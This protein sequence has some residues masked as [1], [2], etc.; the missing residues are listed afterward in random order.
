MDPRRELDSCIVVGAGI[1]G[2][3]AARTLVDRGFEVLV[4]DK[5][6]GVGG[7]MATRWFEPAAGAAEVG[8]AVWD[9][10]A[11]FFTARDGAFKAWVDEWLEAGVARVWADGFAGGKRLESSDGHPR[12]RGSAGMSEIPKHLSQGIDVRLNERVASIDEA[13]GRWRVRADDGETE[14]RAGA[15]IL[16]PPVPQSL[17]LVDAGG[18]RLPEA[19]RGSLERIT[20]A[21]CIALLARIDGASRVPEPGAMRL[22][23][24]PIGWIADNRK[25]GISPEATTLTVHAGPEFSQAHWDSAS[26]EVARLLLEAAAEW[27]GGEILSTQVHRWRYSQPVDLHPEPCLV[28]PGPP[29]LVFAGDAFGGPRVEGAALSG[30]AAAAWLISQ[31]A[32]V[33]SPTTSDRR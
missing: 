15:L 32:S 28:S 19:V 33:G 14:H 31:A 23:G 16:T 10:G 7:R 22:D 4:L 2:L 8:R 24:E 6:R 9:H 29:P 13:E 21:P 26:D 5:A 25:K 18:V 1:A 20:Y 3:L 27:I 12:Y 11:Q 30:L 17:A